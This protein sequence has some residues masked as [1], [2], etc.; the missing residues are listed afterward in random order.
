MNRKRISLLYIGF[1]FAVFTFFVI[2][3]LNMRVLWISVILVFVFEL[4]IAIPIYSRHLYRH[5]RKGEKERMVAQ[6]QINHY[7]YDRW[8]SP[9]DSTE[10]DYQIERIRKGKKTNKLSTVN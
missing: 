4:G 5:S 2:S 10:I 8:Y 6:K 9:A 1:T 3:A 7:F